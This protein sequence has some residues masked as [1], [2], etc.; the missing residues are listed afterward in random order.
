MLFTQLL[1]CFSFKPRDRPRLRVIGDH[2]PLV[3]VLI[4][5]CG[6]ETAVIIDT[7]RAV[8]GIDWPQ[9]RFRIVVLDDKKSEEV[10][11]EVELLALENPNLHYHSRTKVKG[12]PHHFKAGNLNGGLAFIDALEGERAEYVAAVD[13]DMIVER[14]WLRAI[15]AALVHDPKIALACPPQVSRPHSHPAQGVSVLRLT[16]SSCSTI[17]QR[18]IHYIKTWRSFLVFWKL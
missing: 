14:P 18:T 11:R 7:V 3:D 5:C 10:K 2:V 13:A 15:I 8:A 17:Y 9:D 4:T 16:S 6:E 12:V 1:Q